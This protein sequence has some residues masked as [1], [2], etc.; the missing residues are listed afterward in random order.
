[1]ISAAEHDVVVL[2]HDDVGARFDQ[3]A[4]KLALDHG[5]AGGE[6]RPIVQVHDH[7]IDV[8]TDRRHCSHDRGVVSVERGGHSRFAGPADH[9]V[10]RA[11][12]STAVAARKAIRCL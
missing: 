12:S 7:G 2:A 11:S 5:R 10:A 4:G 3:V 6:V 9:D 8:R 1:V